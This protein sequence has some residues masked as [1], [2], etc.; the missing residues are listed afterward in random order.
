M[1]NEDLLAWTLNFDGRVK[2]A[3]KKNFL[4]KLEEVVV[5]PFPP[6]SRRMLNASSSPPL[7]CRRRVIIGWSKNLIIQMT[8]YVLAKYDFLSI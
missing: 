8:S 1:W 2:Q 5:V 4:I 3:S 6:F 7:P